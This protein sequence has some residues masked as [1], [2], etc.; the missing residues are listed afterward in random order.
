MC[1]GKNTILWA[2][3]A[4]FIF[5]NAFLL[6]IQGLSVVWKAQLDDP[7]TCECGCAV[8]FGGLLD[9]SF[10]SDEPEL[11]PQ[12][13]I[14]YAS[15]ERGPRSIHPSIHDPVLALTRGKM[16]WHL[17]IFFLNTM[18]SALQLTFDLQELHCQPQDSLSS[19]MDGSIG[20]GQPVR[21][22]PE[23][24]AAIGRK[25][26]KVWACVF[27]ACGRSLSLSSR[28]SSGGYNEVDQVKVSHLSHQ[29]SP[30][31]LPACS[32]RAL[33]C[34]T[35]RFQVTEWLNLPMW[36]F[37]HLSHRLRWKFEC[38]WHKQK[39]KNL[40]FFVAES[41]SHPSTVKKKSSSDSPPSTTSRLMFPLKYSKGLLIFSCDHF[42]VSFLSELQKRYSGSRSWMSCRRSGWLG[43]LK[44]VRQMVID[45]RAMDQK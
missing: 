34:Q 24:T 8:E 13:H 6:S 4:F 35:H 20:D 10:C 12:S 33:L 31:L 1:L 26:K 9:W 38:S 19:R 17:V 39:K 15:L 27:Y 44:R 41:V 43:F 40:F 14:S 36:V 37:R 18:I 16:G 21:L 28:C 7:R 23:A 29:S 22:M 30:K 45:F 5:R 2:F 25:A 32:S 42:V 3:I 11:L